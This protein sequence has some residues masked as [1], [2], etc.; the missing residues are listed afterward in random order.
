M[1]RIPPPDQSIHH[2]SPAGLDWLRALPLGN[3]RMGAMVFGNPDLERIQLNEDTF[4]TLEPDTC[5]HLPAGIREALPGVTSL[6]QQG[7][8]AEAEEEVSRN[9]LGRSN[10]PYQPLAD[11]WIDAGHSGFA[12]YHHELSLR[13]ATATCR[14]AAEGR[15]FTREVFLSFPDQVLVLRLSCDTPA[16]LRFCVWIDSPHRPALRTRIE[17]TTYIASGRGPAEALRRPHEKI[18]E[19]GD[20]HKYPLFYEQAPNGTWTRRPGCGEDVLYA[21]QADGG[22][23]RFD[24]RL[25]VLTTGGTLRP[26]NGKL[27]VE[28]ADE[29]L[30]LLSADTSFNGMDKSPSRE[31]LDPALQAAADLDAAS[32]RS[33]S[34]LQQR[35][36]NDVRA[37]YDR[38]ELSL[39]EPGSNATLPTDERIARY[40]EGNDPTLPALYYNFSRYLMIA[41]SRPGSEPLNLQGIWNQEVIPPWNCGYTTNINA[42]M[43]Y[44]DVLRGN[45]A[46]CHEPLLRMVR[47]T[48]VNGQRVARNLFGYRGWCMFHNISIWRS[49]APVDGVART[50]WWP[51]GAG[52]F[53]QH[54][55]HHFLVTEDT[56]FLRKHYPILRDAALFFCDWIIDRGDGVLVTPVSTSPENG[57]HYRDAA[58]VNHEASVCMGSTMDMAIVRETF[59]NTLSAA[60]RLGL[61]DPDLEEIRGKLERLADYHIAPNGCLMEWSVNFEE[62]EPLH[63]HISH[64]YGFFPGEDITPEKRPELI[65]AVRATLERRGDGASGWSMGWKLN[66]WA[67]LG[68]GEHFQSLLQN[69]LT[70]ER[71]APNMLCLHP[72]FQIDGNFGAARAI[73]ETLVQDHRGFIELLPALPPA[74]PD[75]ALRGLRCRGGVELDLAWREGK[76]LQ[77]AI[78]SARGGVFALRHGDVD[79]TVDLTPGEK[80]CIRVPL[81]NFRPST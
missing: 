23:M 72:P 45:L 81:E 14:Y 40:P 68:D 28:N 15:R 69:L 33:F 26:E 65:P 3:G 30:L 34:E 60:E 22:G 57:F 52:W 42:E 80:K 63:R 31:G 71:T 16:S 48:H 20:E 49:A 11:L 56:A 62:R 25:R 2:N 17:A 4:Y 67:R 79:F 50:S 18:A 6:L 70:P 38:V 29:A 64:L 5:G 44:W 59:T 77:A 76:L 58:G 10:A 1:K 54:L 61:D 9:W 39:G 41:G 73:S 51:V 8:F 55:W 46:E 24:V 66:G 35:H 36:L 53:C 75:G 74:W 21:E 47:E 13:D 7:K 12:D 19:L 43:N 32:A 27:R 78:R 37:L